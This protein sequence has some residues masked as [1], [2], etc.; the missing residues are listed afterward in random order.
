M[1][2]LT[3][4]LP[5]Q[6]ITAEGAVI[7]ACLLDGNIAVTKALSIVTPESFYSPTNQDLF[8]L[9]QMVHNNNKSVDVITINEAIENNKLQIAFNDLLSYT[10]LVPRAYSLEEYC[11]IIKSCYLKR[12]VIKLANDLVT[13]A[14]EPTNSLETLINDAQDG[15][16][17]IANSTIKS[18]MVHISE[19]VDLEATETIEAIEQGNLKDKN[20]VSTGFKDLDDDILNGGFNPSDLI[21]IAARPAMGKTAFVV[22]LA[23]NI[24]STKNNTESLAVAIFT[25]EM[26]NKQI[27][28]RVISS[29]TNLFLSK[30]KNRYL[31]EKDLESYIAK[32][33]NIKSLP[34]YLDDKSSATVQEIKSKS[35]KLKSDCKKT[36]KRLG[37]VIVD[38]LQLMDIETE[39]TQQNRNN[40]ISKITRGLKK[41]AKEL[42]VPV[43]ALSQLSRTVEQRA[44]K[45]PQLSDLRESGSIEQDADIVMFLYRDEYYNPDSTQKR[46]GEVIIAKHRNGPV[47]TVKLYFDGALTQFKNLEKGSN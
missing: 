3:V 27:T 38:Y 36:G 13:K 4:K 31:E 2:E 28:Q 43:I 18:S 22:N 11:N 39:G 9:I 17:D 41:L 44:N 12:E 32:L 33:P 26:A 23:V 7:G 6:N 34:I 8:R 25:L 46:Q 21:I 16:F 15:I 37:A 30:I 5:P 45:R 42:D 35:F 29:E 14:F 1:N 24:A 47:G 19:V 20:L 40:E 10:E